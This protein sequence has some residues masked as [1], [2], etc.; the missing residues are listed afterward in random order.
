MRDSMARELLSGQ[1]A[2]DSNNGEKK[3][4]VSAQ[5]PQ[6]AETIQISGKSKA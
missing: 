3:P 5:V 6:S 1:N 4:A 2:G